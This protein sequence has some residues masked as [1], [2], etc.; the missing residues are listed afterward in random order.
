MDK[1]VFSLYCTDMD[2]FVSSII[3]DEVSSNRY[4]VILQKGPPELRTM[5]LLIRDVEDTLCGLIENYKKAFDDVVVVPIIDGKFYHIE[6]VPFLELCEW[7]D[8]GNDISDI[9]DHLKWVG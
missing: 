5:E 1:F 8:D 7:C 3:T 4:M 6:S 2:E 9:F